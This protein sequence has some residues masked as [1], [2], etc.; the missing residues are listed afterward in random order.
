MFKIVNFT[1]SN[2]L[3]YSNSLHQPEFVYLSYV[4]YCSSAN[5]IVKDLDKKRK[6][7]ENEVIFEC[8]YS[9]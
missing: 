6:L 9:N 4:Q 8:F 3:K 1:F 2:F 5:S 7:I